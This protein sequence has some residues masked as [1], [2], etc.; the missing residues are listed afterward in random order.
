M[1]ASVRAEVN[2]LENMTPAELRARWREVF[3][4]ETRS[5][6]RRYLVKRLAWRIQAN[7]EGDISERARRRA[8]RLANDADL[9]LRPPK[10]MRLGDEEHV[11]GGVDS[12]D[13]RL[14]IPGTVLAREY[15][16]K[17]VRVTVLDDGFDYAGEFY[18]SLTAVAEAITGSHWNGYH[19]F[20]LRKDR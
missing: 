9:R 8:E 12:E 1:D 5:G 16:G 3:G 11:S 18:S 14:P 10:T 7:A 19:F 17:T 13:L 20:G 6:N 15:K 4:E 2:A